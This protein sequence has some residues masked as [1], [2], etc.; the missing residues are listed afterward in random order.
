MMT[1]FLDFETETER[2][3]LVKLMKFKVTQLYS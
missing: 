1:A 2:N 3:C